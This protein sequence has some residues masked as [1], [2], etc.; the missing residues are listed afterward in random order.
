MKI[1]LLHPEDDLPFASATPHWDLVVDLA[2][3]PVSTYADWSRRTG[4]PVMSLYDLI[5]EIEDL[6]SIKQL[7]RLGRGAMVDRQGIDWWD[8]LSL[9]IYPTLH[10]LMLVGRLASQT[11]QRL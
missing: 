4:G 8:V 7:L 10:R 11:S 9:M 6:R 2:R 5:Q 1:L 3:A